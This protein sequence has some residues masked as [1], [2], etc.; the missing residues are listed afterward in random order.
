MQGNDVHIA[1]CEQ[2]ILTFCFFR[3]I[4]RKQIA[5]FVKYNGFRRIEVLGFAVIHDA[6]AKRDDI[7]AH[8]NN[9]KHDTISEFV[10]ICTSVA[11]HDET[12]GFQFFFGKALLRHRIEQCV[13]GIRRISQPE[14]IQGLFAQSAPLKI[15]QCLRALRSMQLRIEK[16]SCFGQCFQ[17]P[18][19]HMPRLRTA[20]GL[21]HF[22]VVFLG[23]KPNGVRKIQSFCVHNKS[24]RTATLAA[25]EAVENLLIRCNRKRRRF[26]IVKR[27]QSKIVAAFLFQ[28][29]I[30]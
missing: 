1:L 16:T 19:A 29:D 6:A 11:A 9:R 3:P 5:P 27:A 17:R 15:R 7:S 4:H 24:N 10:V 23:K 21:R 20:S 22:H 30:A 28:R 26:L 14:I 8:I 18:F 2:E 13:K 12:R 25:A